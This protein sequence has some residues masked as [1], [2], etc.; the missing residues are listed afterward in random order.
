MSCRR[1][2]A[3]PVR[4]PDTA[5]YA[6]YTQQMSNLLRGA[7]GAGHGADEP[8]AQAI[9]D[10]ARAAFRAMADRSYTT[11]RFGPQ[12]LEIDGRLTFKP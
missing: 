11:V 8:A 7:D 3:L 6:D 1:T 5:T 12:G 2:D 4:G 9:A 10:A